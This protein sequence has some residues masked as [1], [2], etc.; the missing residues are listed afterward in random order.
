MLGNYPIY[1]PLH[2]GQRRS[3]AIYDFYSKNYK[4]TYCG[5]YRAGSYEDHGKT[6]IALSDELIESIE[7][8]DDFKKYDD[9]CCSLA[10]KK[11]DDSLELL[12]KL[13]KSNDIVQLEQPYVYLAVK[14]LLKGKKII[15]S[16]QNIE[17]NTRNDN[18]KIIKYMDDLE[19]QTIELS[20]GKVITCSKEDMN[21]YKSLKKHEIKGVI[22]PNAIDIKK[23][24]KQDEIKIKQFLKENHI[25]DYALFV[26]SYHLP[27]IMGFFELV[28]ARL[29]YLKLGQNIIVA[30]GGGILIKKMIE[31]SK[32]T[33]DKTALNKLYF[34]DK[35]SDSEL[36]ALINFGDMMLLP[37]LSGGGTNLKTA[38]A[39]LTNKKIIAT[40]Y[41]F[42]GYEEYMKRKNVFISNDRESFTNNIINLF[43]T[44]NF[45]DHSSKFNNSKL[46]WSYKF[47]VIG[48]ELINLIEK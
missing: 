41:A 8:G 37:I 19:N 34:F 25:K 29:G 38:E 3:R 48:P 30:G 6:D 12:K 10:V 47:K 9:I 4:T 23:S 26:S 44:D 15:Y 45:L 27:N 32:N 20:R 7:I 35:P 33:L 28:S 24:L 2:G 21:W 1:N 39:L 14:D 16:S 5:I 46:T 36:Q 40:K 18:K 31:E 11:S 13:I 43:V 17:H 22:L 42:R